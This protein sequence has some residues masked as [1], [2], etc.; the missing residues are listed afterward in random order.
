[1]TPVENIVS[2]YNKFLN[3]P[4]LNGQLLECH[5]T[6]QSFLPDA[7]YSDGDSLR[8]TST[9]YEGYFVHLHGENSGIPGAVQ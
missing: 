4:S 6:N 7:P 9:V 1:M 3:D 2:G 8:F 5:R